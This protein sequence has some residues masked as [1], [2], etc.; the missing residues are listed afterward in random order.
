MLCHAD[1][2]PAG[3]SLSQRQSWTRAG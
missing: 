2:D 1:K 3:F